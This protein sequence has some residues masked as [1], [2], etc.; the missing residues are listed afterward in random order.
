MQDNYSHITKVIPT[1][2]VPMKFIMTK[3]HVDVH[4]WLTTKIS[5]HNSY[6][7][8]STTKFKKKPF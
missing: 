2:F 8:T 5:S 1:R 4:V 7:H 3:C 6:Y